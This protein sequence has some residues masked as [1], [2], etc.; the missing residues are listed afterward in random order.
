MIE[1]CFHSW[2]KRGV[3]LI[4]IGAISLAPGLARNTSAGVSTE[5]GGLTVEPYI[6]ALQPGKYDP[7]NYLPW[8]KASVWPGDEITPGVFIRALDLNISPKLKLITQ[9]S[10]EG[11]LVI[12][13]CEL[14]NSAN[15]PIAD[16]VVKAS[17]EFATEVMQ[18]G[19][20]YLDE[21]SISRIKVVEG[22]GKV[23]I[24]MEVTDGGQGLVSSHNTSVKV[25]RLF[26]IFLPL[27]H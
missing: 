9:I 18:P 15:C 5:V 25:P 13:V 14:A 12:R 22:E 11:S 23:N 3:Q 27:L 24:D 21:V 19:G 16:G 1:R 20:T 17:R 2:V 10:S 4:F 6:L 26:R 7:L 8:D